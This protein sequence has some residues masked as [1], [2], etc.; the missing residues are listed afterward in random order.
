MLILTLISVIIA[1]AAWSAMRG[2]NK[3]FNTAT[4]AEF[5]QLTSDTANVQ[6]VDVRTTTEYAEGHIP[7]AILIDVHDSMFLSN[8]QAQLSTG[9]TVALYC[10]SG[11]RSATAARILTKAGYKV[12]HLKGGILAWQKEGREIKQ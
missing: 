2:H 9:K 7:G 5:A 3:G 1:A 4:P 12:T 10:R 6:L 11:R 8:A